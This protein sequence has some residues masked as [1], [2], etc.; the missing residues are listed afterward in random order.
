MASDD[1]YS[2]FDLNADELDTA[3]LA[4]PKRMKR[5][6][7]KVADAD[8]DYEAAKA[9]LDLVKAELDLAIRKNPK[10]FGLEKLSEGAI[11]S[12][13]LTQQVYSE[14]H[15]EMLKQKHRVA[16][17]KS[18]VTALDHNRSALE[19]MV[20]LHGQSYFATPRASQEDVESMEDSAHDRIRGAKQRKQK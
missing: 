7:R 11:N 2:M 13:I 18:N 10:K 1:D 6:C 19:G 3:W 9:E 4:Q 5:A 12:T 8:A 15:S 16:V 14:A 20:K 17:M